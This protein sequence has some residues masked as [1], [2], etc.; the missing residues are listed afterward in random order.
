MRKS[1]CGFC[2]SRPLERS[3]APRRAGGGSAH[4]TWVLPTET[5]AKP[6][7]WLRRRR[8]EEGQLRQNHGLEA[9]LS[10]GL[11]RAALTGIFQPPPDA[12]NAPRVP[13][14]H[15][16]ALSSALN[17]LQDLH[18]LE[19]VAG[20]RLWPIERLAAFKFRDLHR[21]VASAHGRLS[22]L[23][24]RIR[25][26]YEHRGLPVPSK[27][28]RGAT[29]RQRPHLRLTWKA[30]NA[31]PLAPRAHTVSRHPRAVERLREPTTG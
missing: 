28:A 7:L 11:P 10:L 20:T 29:K 31:V 2:P 19:A 9:Q 16:R 12:R 8:R 15:G 23:S 26:S 24:R 1:G 27:P 17:R 3:N 30:G 22:M 4:P 13:P 6:L 5:P 14:W 25:G 21:L 18:A